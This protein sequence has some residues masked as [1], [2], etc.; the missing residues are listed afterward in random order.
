LISLKLKDN[1][2]SS[3]GNILNGQLN[4]EEFDITNNK[5]KEYELE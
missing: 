4:V 3:L 5:I 2:I 1:R